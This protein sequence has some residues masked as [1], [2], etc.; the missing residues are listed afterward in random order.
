[1]TISDRM[2]EAIEKHEGQFSN[3][4]ELRRLQQFLLQ[5]KAAGLARTPE[6]DL[7]L[8]DTLGRAI[9]ENVQNK[10]HQS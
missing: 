4:D 5:M 9:V 2:K 8:P 3:L 10:P 6:Y 7:P 1:M